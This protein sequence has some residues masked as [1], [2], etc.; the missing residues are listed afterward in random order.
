MLINDKDEIYI[1][2]SRPKS[3]K[4]HQQNLQNQFTLTR[5]SLNR[6]NQI[7]RDNQ[8]WHDKIND[9]DYVKESE[10]TYQ[11]MKL[12]LAKKQEKALKTEIRR[13]ARSIKDAQLKLK[14]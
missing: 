3:V 12:R 2:F 8:I 5:L 9:P 11:K 10:A 1:K 4:A 13:R 14:L 6:A 7:N